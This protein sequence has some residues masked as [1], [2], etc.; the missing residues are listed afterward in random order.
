MCIVVKFSAICTGGN[1]DLC[2]SSAVLWPS[3]LS[4][5][6]LLSFLWSVTPCFAQPHVRGALYFFCSHLKAKQPYPFGMVSRSETKIMSVH[7]H[8]ARTKRSISTSVVKKGKLVVPFLQSWR[9]WFDGGFLNSVLCLNAYGRSFP[10]WLLIQK[11]RPWTIYRAKI[12]AHTVVITLCQA[13]HH[14]LACSILDTLN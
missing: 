6:V 4:H 14:D 12:K 11:P 9:Y 1:G 10:R 2:H 8:A 5:K 7:D 3:G 13:E